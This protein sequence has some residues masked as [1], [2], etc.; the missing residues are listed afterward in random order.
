MT[1]DEKVVVFAGVLTE[2]QGID[3]LLEAI[4]LVARE[5]PRV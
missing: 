4:S 2:Y 1:T 5:I 3:L